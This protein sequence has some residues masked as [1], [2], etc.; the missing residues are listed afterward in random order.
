[1]Q[2]ISVLPGRIRFKHRSL[3]HNKALS[4]YISIYADNLYGVKHCSVNH[5]TMSILV[6][7]DPLKTN[8]DVIQKN[9]ENAISSSM[10]N[11]PEKIRG[12]DEYCQTI[13]KRDAAKRNLILYGLVS[14]GLEIKSSMFGRFTFST[15]ARVL[16]AAAAVTIIGGY[17]VFKT[18]YKKMSKR[19]PADSD[20]VLSLAALSFTLLRESTKGVLLLMMK[21]MNDYI[22]Y[23][24]DAECMRLLNQSMNK[25]F[26]TAWL[27]SPSKQE[28]LVNTDSLKAGDVIAAHEGEVI[29]VLG[30]VIDGSALINSL[31]CTGQSAISRMVKGSR[32]QEGISVI[33]GDLAIMVEKPVE[34]NEE[35]VMKEYDSHIHREVSAYQKLITPAALWAGAASF[36]LSGNAMNALSVLLALAPTGTQTALNSGIKSTISLLNRHKIFI[37]RPETFEKLMKVEHV[38]FDKTGTLTH[39]RMNLEFI[40][41]YDSN[42][43]E[44]ELLRICAACES[45]HY[46]PIAVTLKDRVKEPDAGKVSDSILIPSKGV[47][48]AYEAHAVI[49]GSKEFMNENGV[50]TDEKLESYEDCKRRVLTPIFVSIDGRLTGLIAFTDALKEGSDE[51]VR[52]LKQKHGLET[53][54]LTGDNEYKARDVAQRLDIDNVHSACDCAGKC[55]IIREYRNKHSVMMVGDG[56]ND[57]DAMKEADI[58]VSFANSACDLV[59]L[60][61]DYIIFEDH[62]PRLADML[63]LSQHAYRRINQSISISQICNI[64]F[65]A[66][67]FTGVID[68]FTAKSINTVNSLVVMLL[69]KTIEYIGTDKH[70]E[71]YYGN[72]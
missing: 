20:I 34:R 3:Y 42:Y 44:N 27:V 47:K 24:A 18:V 45:D 28:V 66:L 69:N 17:P 11:K 58:S 2:K 8:C 19:M 26:G 59:K 56:F 23:S 25:T 15:N 70:Y 50:N 57:L 36:I 35:P 39:G 13:R 55:K 52:R 65:G 49:I 1:M 62:M 72:L 31:Y 5:N 71:R 33:S 64:I 48:A 38:I 10:Q 61:S 40:E 51:L 12:N 63:S 67:A 60:N 41:S 30:E 46:H 22:K 37:R 6:V 54:L 9:I 53:S 7:Y 29:P 21:A 68:A 4:A 32:V 43:T 14:L 16:K